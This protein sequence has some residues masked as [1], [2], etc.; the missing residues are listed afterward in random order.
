MHDAHTLSFSD[1]SFTSVSNRCRSE[2][3][4][5]RK[6]SMVVRLFSSSAD[7]YVCVCVCVNVYVCMY[8]CVYVCM[9]FGNRPWLCAF[10]LLQ[11]ICMCVCVCVNVYVCMY[12]CIYVCMRFGSRPWLCAFFLHQQICMCVCVCVNVYVCM[13]VCMC[14]SSSSKSLLSLSLRYTQTHTYIV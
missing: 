10:Y 13:Y 5:L 12:V 8:I 6:S 4:A 11:R 2:S 3:C 9:H 7:L 1:S 14:F